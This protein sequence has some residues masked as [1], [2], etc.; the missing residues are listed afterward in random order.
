[1]KI[2]N[3]NSYYYSSS[4]HKQLQDAIQSLK[5]ESI[6]YVP[7]ARGYIPRI[8]C[9]YENENNVIKSECYNKIDRYVFYI[10]HIKILKDIEHHIHLEQFNCLHAHSLFSNGYIAMNIK[11]LLKIP[12][13]VVVRDTDLN[14]FFKY[15]IYLRPLGLNIIKDANNIVFLSKAYRD[16]LIQEYIPEKLK[17]EIYTKSVIIPNGIDEFWLNNKG[18]PKHL[19]DSKT[20]KLLYVGAIS[21]RKNIDTSISAIEIL[22]KKGFNITFTIVGKIVDEDIFKKIKELPYVNYIQHI[23][24]EELIK[25]YRDN[26]IFIMP[27]KTETFG[28]VYAEAMSQGLPVIY[29][30]GQGFDGHFEEGEVGYSVNCFDANEITEKIINI[31]NVYE[32]LSKRCIKLCDRF[33]WKVIAKQYESLYSSINNI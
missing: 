9:C 11:K 10:K 23:S 21:K 6:S 16:F 2:L 14:M 5:I 7:L 18:Y 29:T 19:L 8:E 26:D 12:Y 3:I 13:I 31:I 17:K 22:N 33:N 4:V 25:V 32:E 15:M 27:S 20:L 28:L 1:M 30:R 24:K